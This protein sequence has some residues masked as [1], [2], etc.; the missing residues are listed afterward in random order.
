[1]NL[2]RSFTEFDDRVA[3]SQARPDQACCLS[4]CTSQA[5]F[6]EESTAELDF[7]AERNSCKQLEL[8]G[9]SARPRDQWQPAYLRILCLGME[10]PTVT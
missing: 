1:L 8:R 4:N 7:F 10:V 9:N 3:M 2:K 6:E 5:N